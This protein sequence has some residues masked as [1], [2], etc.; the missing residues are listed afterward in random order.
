M[1]IPPANIAGA[2]KA[3]QEHGSKVRLQASHLQI[4]QE[5][6][7]AAF[8]QDLNVSLVYY[9]DRHSLLLAAASDELFKTLHKTSQYL[10]KGRNLK[11]DKS[12][13]LHELLIDEQID[14]GD[15]DLV[16]ELQ[17]ELGIL[18]VQL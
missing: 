12:V 5:V 17:G 15:R 10:L 9:A 13:A 18:N 1:F 14:E 7:S 4:D 3:R 6:A 11:G 2:A 8:G 16:F